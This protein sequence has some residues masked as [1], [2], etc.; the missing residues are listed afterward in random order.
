MPAIITVP[1]GLQTL[2]GW[3][4]G[5]SVSP[6]NDSSCPGQY[7]TCLPVLMSTPRTAP[8]MMT[9]YSHWRKHP[10]RQPSSKGL[11][12]PA[13]ITICRL[14]NWL[15][16]GSCAP[17]SDLHEIPM[18]SVLVVFRVF[19]NDDTQVVPG[20]QNLTCCFVSWRRQQTTCSLWRMS[21]DTQETKQT[22]E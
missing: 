4:V 11:Y 9:Q 6:A 18:S 13:A 22:V 1:K 15:T 5:H 2:T 21:K 16:D 8:E 10:H 7:R 12:R 20:N 14:S 3:I 19:N 17:S